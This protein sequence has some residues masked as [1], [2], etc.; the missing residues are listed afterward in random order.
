MK[1]SIVLVE[2]ENPGNLGAICRVMGNFAISELLV[3]NPKCDLSDIEAVKRAKHAKYI[4]E[5]I[6]Q[7]ELADLNHDLIV[8]TTAQ[9]AG[10]GNIVRAPLELKDMVDKLKETEGGSLAIVFGREGEGLHND[11]LALMDYTITIPTNREYQTLNLS[12]SVGIVCYE[13]FQAFGTEHMSHYVKGIEYLARDQKE[14]LFEKFDSIVEKVDFAI[15]EHEKIRA[16]IFKKI[17]N[18]SNLTKRE[19]Y[20]LFGLLKAIEKSLK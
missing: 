18:K 5:N 14:H 13:L 2:P 16:Q 6:K 3:V 4:L 7:V 15:T 8:G 19:G 20:A 1:I 17:V 12:H 11:E 10:Q 9:I